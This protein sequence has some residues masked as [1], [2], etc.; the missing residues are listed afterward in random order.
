MTQDIWNLLSPEGQK[1]V[2]AATVREAL[3]REIV[4]NEIHNDGRAPDRRYR[5]VRIEEDGGEYELNFSP[6]TTEAEI[7]AYPLKNW[8]VI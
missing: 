1:R 3:A 8:R 7:M 4:Y 5:H 6:E 2:I